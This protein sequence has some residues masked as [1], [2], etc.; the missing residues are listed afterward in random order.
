VRA[1][2]RISV[3]HL[4]HGSAVL[5]ELIQRDGLAVV[6][7]EYDVESGRVDFFDTAGV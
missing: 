2:A 3:E 5:E 7:G 6:G 1:N 4:R